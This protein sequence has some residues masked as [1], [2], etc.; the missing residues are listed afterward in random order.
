MMQFSAKNLKLCLFVAVSAGFAM[1]AFAGAGML[2]ARA[3]SN[4]HHELLPV[5]AVDPA[6]RDLVLG[7]DSLAV[8]D[9]QRSHV[10]SRFQLAQPRDELSR[11]PKHL[12]TREA[13]AKRKR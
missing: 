3:E 1:P 6:Q 5:W 10:S 11:S 9:A 7:S 8:R 4:S 12:P 2:L 13:L